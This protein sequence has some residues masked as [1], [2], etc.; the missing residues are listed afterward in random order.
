MNTLTEQDFIAA[1]ADLNCEVAAVKAVCQV[2]APRGG[3]NPDGTPVTLF[4]GHKFFKFTNGAY[5]VDAPDLCYPKW[6]RV[7]YGKT[8]QAEQGRLTRAIALDREAALKSASWG[9]FQLMGFNHIACG[10]DTVEEFV[11][12]MATGEPAQLQAFINFIRNSGLAPALR[13][14]DW[15]GFAAGYN[16]PAFDENDYDGKLAMA[17]FG[18]AA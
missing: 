17:Y 8:W 15:A 7:H 2:E 14:R 11:T 18:F 5:A 10:F 4:E 13:R 12:A 16:G 1:A 9:R 3:F 6:T